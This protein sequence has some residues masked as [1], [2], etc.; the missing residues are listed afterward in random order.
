MR[1]K[2]RPARERITAVGL[3]L[4]DGSAEAARKTGIPERTIQEWTNRPEFAELRARTK[5]QVAEEWWAIVQKGVRRVADLLDSAEDVQKVA[6]AT[7]IVTDKML[8]LRG[9]ATART[10]STLMQGKSDHEQR[11]LADLINAELERRADGDPDGHQAPDSVE[12]PAPAEAG[13]SPG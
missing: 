5:D 11:I 6:T 10:E 3:A 8:L 4:V 2:K 9:E 12:E 13:T 7:A 1:G